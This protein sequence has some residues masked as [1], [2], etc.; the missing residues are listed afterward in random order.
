MLL[1]SE[2][3]RQPVD[4]RLRAL[5]LSTREIDVLRCVERGQSDREIARGL[6]LSPGTIKKHLEHV[7]RKLGVSSRTAAI[8]RVRSACNELSP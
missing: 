2:R 6:A 8:A 7:Y 1:L 4:E 5:G 3:R